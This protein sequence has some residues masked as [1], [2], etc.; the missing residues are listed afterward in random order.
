MHSKKSIVRIAARA[1]L[2]AVVI[3]VLA[4]VA[5][6]ATYLL[7]PRPAPK[8]VANPASHATSPPQL[9]PTLATTTAGT[10]SALVP[11]PANPPVISPASNLSASERVTNLAA[12]DLAHG[13]LAPEKATAWKQSLRQL[14]AKGPAAIPAIRDFLNRKQDVPFAA[15]G[16][17]EALGAPSLRLA[18]LGVLAEIGGPE[19]IATAQST[20]QATTDPVEL[21]TL[22]KFLDR[23]EPGAHRA[24]FTRA[25]KATL[26][27][28]VSGN[29]GGRDVAPLF[30]MMR[31]FGGPAELAELEPYANHWFNY[32]PITLAQAPDGAGLP[33]LIKLAQN[34][35]GAIT[36]GQE[37]YQRMLAELAV[38]SP[39]AADAL[40]ALVRGDKIAATAWPAVGR[41]LTGQTLH[42]AKSYLNPP[43]PLVSRPDTR[44]FHLAYGNQ[45][46]VEASLPED[47]PAPALSDRLRLIDRLLEATTNQPAKEALI[48]ARVALSARLPPGK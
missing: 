1:L 22:A 43:S 11:P 5:L 35:S 42:I 28:A 17:A 25:A 26:A 46:F 15:P 6:A 12:I 36:L 23:A 47:T 13:P 7:I 16:A 3:G 45:N 10:H 31:T 48:D 40:E 38:N 32:T 29:L 41:A 9:V 39:V 18:L 34:E 37:V 44:T 20:L 8:P 30:E 33:L 14:A 24:E 21:V 4:L 27:V 19:A 2:M